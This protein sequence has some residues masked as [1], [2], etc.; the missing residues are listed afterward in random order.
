MDTK[1]EG[2]LNWEMGIDGYTLLGIKQITR[3]SLL[4]STGNSTQCSVM[5]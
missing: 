5:A 4:H 3:E 2:G 1:G